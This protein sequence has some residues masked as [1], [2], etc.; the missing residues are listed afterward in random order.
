VDFAALLEHRVI[1]E[2]VGKDR[3]GPGQAE[4]TQ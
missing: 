4:K 1:A 3:I 2:Q